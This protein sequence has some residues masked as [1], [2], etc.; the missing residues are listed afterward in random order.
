MSIFK[1]TLTAALVAVT[2]QNVLA[3]E[4]EQQSGA[5]VE[6]RAQQILVADPQTILNMRR[7]IQ[8]SSAARQAPIVD[9]FSDVVDQDVVDLD[10]LFDV[11]LQPDSE[12]PRIAIARF[13][14]SAVSFIDAY[15]NP[16]PI[17]RVSSYME[18]MV[19]IDRATGDETI[20]LDDPQAG[21]FTLTALKHG[22]VGNLTVYLHG[23]AT[24]ITILLEGKAG[25][26]HR[27]ATIRVAE[28]GPQTDTAAMFSDRSV[29]V[30]A[31]AN[32]DLNSVLYGVS[33]IGSTQMVV[34]GAEG[35]AWIK[36]E[37]LFL[38]TPLAVFSPKIIDVSH[39]N[40]RYRAYELPLTTMVGGT[41]NSGQ[42]V[43]LR[44]GRAPVAE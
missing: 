34:E 25:I 23:L 14:S 8:Q 1:M 26:Y 3:Q 5:A 20:E 40:G 11:S 19:A 9:D 42:T 30:G 41:N 29:K 33:P 32:A 18:G 37:S 31:S 21:S 17:R 2:A 15:G 6:A 22:V 35:K 7:E 36:G 16:W 27:S 10:T 12:V 39:G 24:P 43:F 4:S 13:Q 44:I 28:V 38:Q